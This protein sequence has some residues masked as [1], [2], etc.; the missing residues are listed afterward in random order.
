MSTS[1]SPFEGRWTIDASRSL[2]WDEASGTHVPDEVG[3][4][5]ITI[6][7]DGVT[8][9]YEVLYGSEPTIRM[10][11][12]ARYDDP[13]FVPNAVREVIGDD[14]PESIDAFKKKLNVDASGARARNFTVGSNYGLV[15]L[16]YVDE[17]THYRGMVNDA[18]EPL[19]MMLRRMS[20]DGN[21]Y[22]ASVLDPEG[23]LY[24]IRWFVR[25]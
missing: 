21:S 13:E 22:L 19:A 7:D 24:R 1:P 25:L 4:E 17:R 23:V 14:S 16:H 2:V 5:V 9:D 11:Y 20:P 12:T 10:G 15:R 6:K 8:Q 3:Y 18:G